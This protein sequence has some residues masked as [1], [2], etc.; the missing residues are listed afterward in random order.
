MHIFYDADGYFGGQG[1]TIVLA[2]MILVLVILRMSF[3]HQQP[4]PLD[5]VAKPLPTIVLA[6]PAV[7]ER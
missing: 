2:I 6:T 1:F 4:D 3:A 7:A 5:Y